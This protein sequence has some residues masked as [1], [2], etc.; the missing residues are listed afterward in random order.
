MRSNATDIWK[1]HDGCPQLTC[2]CA[3][4]LHTPDSQTCQTL[5]SFVLKSD[6]RARSDP[7]F[8]RPAGVSWAWAPP[9][10]PSLTPLACGTPPRPG[11][12]P[13]AERRRRPRRAQGR[14]AVARCRG[15]AVADDAGRKDR[16]DDPGRHEGSARTARRFTTSCLAPCCRAPT[17]CPSPTSRDLDRDVRPLPEP[18]AGDAARDPDALRRRR[19]PRPRRGQGRDDL[20]AQHRHGLHARSRGRRGGR[21]RDRARDRGHRDRLELRAVP[22]GR[23]RRALGPHVREL[24]R[25]ARAGREPGR[26]RHPRLRAGDRRVRRHPRH[27][28]ALPRPTAAR[29]AARTRAT[30]ASP[31]KT[32]AASTCPATSPPSR[33][34]SAA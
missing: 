12:T 24:R 4:A 7:R 20:P 5:V 19:R 25:I 23:A 8:F 27:R 9:P 28:E 13:L 18:G 33:R 15:A 32:C 21:A 11:A 34:A 3:S 26:R 22:R 31:R 30:R 16:P 29:R 10:A 14:P 17:R 2:V 1:F 6:R